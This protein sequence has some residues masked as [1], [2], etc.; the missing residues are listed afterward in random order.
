[1][2]KI[3]APDTPELMVLREQKH[4][5]TKNKRLT[6]LVAVAKQVGCELSRLTKMIKRQKFLETAKMDQILKYKVLVSPAHSEI[7]NV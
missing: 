6:V 5:S 1:L 7:D 2:F 3:S 4:N